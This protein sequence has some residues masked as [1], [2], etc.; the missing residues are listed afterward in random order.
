M[1]IAGDEAR[2]FTDLA[3]SFRH[4]DGSVL[5]A[6]LLVCCRTHSYRESRQSRCLAMPR[7]NYL[8][9][10]R[11]CQSSSGRRK[12]EGS[13]SGWRLRSSFPCPL[14]CPVSHACRYR[15][16]ASNLRPV[17]SSFIPRNTPRSTLSA[18]R[19][20]W[21]WLSHASYSPWF[22]NVFLY[23]APLHPLHTSLLPLRSMYLYKGN[24]V[25]GPKC[26][27]CSRRMCPDWS[28]DHLPI[29]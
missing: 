6:V 20:A 4:Q 14:G 24:R 2:L 28:L 17:Q 16:T 7:L 3:A 22:S 5:L 12:S 27:A 29:I 9:G 21:A 18:T 25:Y 13:S 1:L 10:R 23:A 19:L 8:Y 26:R 15:R 11:G